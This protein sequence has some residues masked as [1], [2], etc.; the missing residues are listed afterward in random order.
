MPLVLQDEG[1]LLMLHLVLVWQEGRSAAAF[2]TCVVGG[3]P[4]AAAFGTCV[5]GGGRSAAAFGTCEAGG[6]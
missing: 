4:S 6:G 2:D 1:D 3:Q 5:A